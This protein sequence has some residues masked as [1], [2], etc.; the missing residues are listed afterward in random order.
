M[1]F[2]TDAEIHA[3]LSSTARMFVQVYLLGLSI[4]AR[5]ERLPPGDSYRCG[6]GFP[7]PVSR[8]YM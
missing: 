4:G 3:R 5:L 7:A 2:H 1:S 8:P 6:R